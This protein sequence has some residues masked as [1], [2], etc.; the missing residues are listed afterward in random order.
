MVQIL[1]ADSVVYAAVAAY[2][3]I[4]IC[5]LRTSG[6]LSAFTGL[7]YAPVWI[8]VF[9][10]LFP[11]VYGMLGV[12]HVVHRVDKRRRLAFRMTFSGK[13]LAHFGAGLVLLLA[14]MI[15]HEAAGSIKDALPVWRGSFLYDAVQANID[16]LLHFG[17]D[18]WRYLY[19]VAGYG[20]VRAIVEWNYNQ[21]WFI[22]C[23]SALFWV[24]VA[25]EARAIRTRYMICYILVWIVIGNIFAGVFLSAGPAFY[26][27][28]T[29][30]MARFADQMA[31]LNQGGSGR[32]SAVHIQ[33]YLWSLYERREQGLGSG[34]SAFPSMHVSLVTLNALFLF[35]F[36]RK[37]GLATFAYVALIV[38]S[39]VYLAWHYAI[40][41]YVAIILTIVVYMVVRHAMNIMPA[42]ADALEPAQTPWPA[43]DVAV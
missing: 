7:H 21:G 4:A 10:L 15:F 39:S 11:F 30:D 26:G 31:F 38:A 14:I 34:I 23:F 12:L 37:W 1:R 16:R 35:E 32:H 36:N 3:A 13:Q 6:V 2:A 25:Y 5:V 18:P 20:S 19:A 43:K 24:A 40:D 29:G 33:N 8:K 22:V 28:V 9:F 17:E 42:K 41:G 27:H